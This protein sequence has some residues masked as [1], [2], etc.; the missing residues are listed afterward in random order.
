M[1]SAVIFAGVIG[2]GYGESFIFDNA[3]RHGADA[4]TL[5]VF[6]CCATIIFVGHFAGDIVDIITYSRIGHYQII[7][8]PSSGIITSFDGV[9]T[10]DC[11]TD[12]HLIGDINI[13]VLIVGSR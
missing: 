5:A 1:G 4:V 9:N 12:F 3:E 2:A 7:G 10:D 8:I 13:L 6:V 11:T